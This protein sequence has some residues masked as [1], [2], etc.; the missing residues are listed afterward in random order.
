M[1]F[2]KQA[3]KLGRHNDSSALK[4]YLKGKEKGLVCHEHFSIILR[5]TRDQPHHCLT[6]IA[7]L[8]HH[9]PSEDRKAEE[10]NNVKQGCHSPSRF[11]LNFNTSLLVS[12]FTRSSQM[13]IHLVLSTLFVCL[14]RCSFRQ[15]DAIAVALILIV[16]HLESE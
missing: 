10:K 11:R 12:F 4:P 9:E 13:S 2:A 6:A 15:L 16:K 3:I 7:S 8:C 5:R 14:L 1:N